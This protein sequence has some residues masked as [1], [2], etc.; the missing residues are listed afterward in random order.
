MSLARLGGDAIHGAPTPVIAS[1]AD[2]AA[3]GRPATGDMTDAVIVRMAA[4][5][6]DPDA[7]F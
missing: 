2:L 1:A 7:R 4:I 5:T 6:L 3:L